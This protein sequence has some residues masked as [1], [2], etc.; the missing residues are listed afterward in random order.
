MH[1]AARSFCTGRAYRA[2]AGRWMLPWALQGL[3][4]GDHVLEIGAGSGAM[5]AQ[6]LRAHPRLRVAVTDYDPGM[7]ATAARSVAGFGDRA[8]VQ[9]ADAGALP[10]ADGS[11]DLVLSCA[12]LH[13]VLH[14]ENALGEA[15]R[16]LRP[17]GYLAGYDVL[18]SPPMRLLHL[19]EGGQV[20]MMRAGQLDVELRRLQLT[21]IRVRRSA[22]G[23]VAR[24]SA[25]KHPGAC[26]G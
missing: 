19:A 17:G 24:F 7:V 12:M 25:R 11:F 5:A 21:E 10:F 13:H 18:D 22:A 8:S 20:R 26:H 14:W 9:E 4:P 15:A 6:L 16:V 23:L 1:A 3:D 2:L